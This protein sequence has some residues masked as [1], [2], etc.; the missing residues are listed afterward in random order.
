[1]QYGYSGLY[2]GQSFSR[3]GTRPTV[4]SFA[5]ASLIRFVSEHQLL[6][7]TGGYFMEGDGG[8]GVMWLRQARGES[9]EGGL[10][11]IGAPPLAAWAGP[12]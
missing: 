10:T 2:R 4:G 3:Q 6:I 1:M 9:E 11:L 5:R 7:F 8:L 12:E